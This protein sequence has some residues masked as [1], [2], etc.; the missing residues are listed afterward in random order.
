MEQHDLFQVFPRLETERFILRKT[1]ERDAGD[2]FELYSDE[3]VVTYTPLSPFST[4]EDA[5]QEMNWHWEIFAQ[6]IGLRWVIEEKCS[7]KMI[8]TC[9][10]LNY[11]KEHGLTEIGYDLAPS[12][13]G[14]GIMTEV[15]APILA[16]GFHSMKLNRIEAKVDPANEAS[17]RLL[18]KLGF[19]QESE[20]R[21][22]ECEKGKFIKL[23]IFSLLRKEFSKSFIL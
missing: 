10:F 21:E 5:W 17:I 15:A 13:W 16:F 7:G 18:S 23:S 19:G 22:Y 14:R 11:L 20:L 9:G 6:Q 2:L 8:G 4:Q 1:E 3:Q 12:F